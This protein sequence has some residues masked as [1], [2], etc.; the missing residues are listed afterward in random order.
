MIN[1][2][3]SN[4]NHLTVQQENLLP[5]LDALDHV[6][7]TMMVEVENAE[8]ID[9]PTTKLEE[10]LKEHWCRTYGYFASQRASELGTFFLAR[11]KAIT[12]I[13]P[14]KKIRRRLYAA[15]VYP[16]SAL[17]LMDKYQE[18]KEHATTGADY[19]NW[20]REKRFGYIAKFVKLFESISKFSPGK[21][22]PESST[23]NDVLH[24]WLDPHW[25]DQDEN[26]L[27]KI[28]TSK[29]FPSKDKTYKWYEYVNTE[30]IYRLNWGI[31]S[32]IA[33]AFFETTQGESTFSNIDDWPQ[34]DL[35]WIVFWLKDLITWGTLEPVAAYLLAR[36][37]SNIV[38]RFE[39]ERRSQHYYVAQPDY[40]STN[41]LLDPRL[42]RKWAMEV[43][44]PQRGTKKPRQ[45]YQARTSIDIKNPTN[46]QLRVIPII[47]ENRLEWFDSAGYLI[48]TSV[49]PDDW[50]V[51]WIDEWDFVFNTETEFVKTNVY[52]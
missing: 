29:E 47:Q 17:Q 11:S 14:D 23:L 49:K 41:D 6:I 42:I 36:G 34:T 26:I 24:W 44:I 48:A 45:R 46:K 18:I 33:L 3:P 15:N 20:E 2:L 51:N 25:C 35:P 52:L 1:S 22:T 16:R 28:K 30:F 7:L 10:K 37:G 21:K 43:K 31:G 39:A 32:F 38:T 40:Y 13:Y 19:V 4:S 8:I 27:K 12:K 9:L 5:S 50:D